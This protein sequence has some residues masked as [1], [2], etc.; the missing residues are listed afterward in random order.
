MKLIERYVQTGTGGTPMR[1]M[2][3]TEREN[4]NYVSNFTC[5]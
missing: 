4:K 2:L 5:R 1:Y 3:Y